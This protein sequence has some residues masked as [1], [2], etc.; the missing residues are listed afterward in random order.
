MIGIAESKRFVPSLQISPWEWD[1]LETLISASPFSINYNGNAGAGDYS[2]SSSALHGFPSNDFTP[3]EFELD[4]E[5]DMPIDAFSSDNFRMF[6]FKVR[7]CARG[8]SHDWTECPYAHPGEKARRRD[9]RKFHYSA[10]V[11]PEF[12]KG[13]CNKGDYCEFA[14]GV[15]ESWLHPARY[16]TQLCKDGTNCRRRVCFFA[17]TSEQLRVLTHGSVESSNG[18]PFRH[19]V[20]SLRST[21]ASAFVSSPTSVL[22]SSPLSD[23]PPTRPTF[24]NEYGNVSSEAVSEIVT[25][26]RNVQIDNM[27]ASARSSQRGSVFGQTIR[28]GFFSLPSTPTGTRAK[29]KSLLDLWD[30]SDKEEPAMERVESGR[31]L[32]AKIYAKL[33]KENSFGRNDPG[34]SAP[35]FGWISEL[36][37]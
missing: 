31:D 34:I 5:F 27:P 9:P 1:P 35:D 28:P 11:C 36:V 16:R 21:N 7:K 8:R 10:T 24:S 14:H 33:S 29:N 20:D 32:R 19:A 17:H 25:S 30:Q 22:N 13:D 18:S 15:F 12:R 3:I 26:M 4:E 2:P 6:E 23:S 37:K